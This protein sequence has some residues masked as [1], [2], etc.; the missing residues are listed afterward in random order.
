MTREPAS[1]GARGIT[2]RQLIVRFAAGGI[3]V[4]TLP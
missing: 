2:R 4:G 3:A 1:S